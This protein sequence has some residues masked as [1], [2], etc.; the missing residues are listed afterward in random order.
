M[1]SYPCRSRLG[2]WWYLT[3]FG[4]KMSNTIKYLLQP[5]LEQRATIYDKLWQ[6]TIRAT[7]FTLIQLGYCCLNFFNII[8]VSKT[9]SS[10]CR[11]HDWYNDTFACKSWRTTDSGSFEVPSCS[12]WDVQAARTSVQLVLSSSSLEPLG[13]PSCEEGCPVVPQTVLS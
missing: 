3:E 8:S 4:G 7:C 2:Q 6:D 10:F 5:Q 9:K 11:E 13:V 12:K 1:G